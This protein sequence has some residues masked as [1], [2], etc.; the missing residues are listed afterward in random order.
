MQIGSAGV[1]SRLER[2]AADWWRVGHELD[3]SDASM[4]KRIKGWLVVDSKRVVDVLIRVDST[5][6]Q[7]HDLTQT[8]IIGEELGS[9]ATVNNFQT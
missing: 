1:A 2:R 4:S 9:R 5:I 3:G 8:R 6:L 7:S